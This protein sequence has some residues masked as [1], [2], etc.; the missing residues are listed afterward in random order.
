MSKIPDKNEKGQ[1]GGKL[2]R[3]DFLKLSIPAMGM[4]AMGGTCLSSVVA[5]APAECGG[6]AV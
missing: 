3:R 1:G 5:A 4:V 6:D 2:N